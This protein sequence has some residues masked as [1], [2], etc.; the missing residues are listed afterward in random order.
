MAPWPDQQRRTARIRYAWDDHATASCENSRR[1]GRAS[2]TK[3]CPN[4]ASQAEIGVFA[5]LGPNRMGRTKPTR[6]RNQPE[7]QAEPRESA[8]TRPMRLV[9]SERNRG[10]QAGPARP[11]TPSLRQ[12]GRTS[13]ARPNMSAA[14]RTNKP[15]EAKTNNCARAE[16]T[17]EQG[18][19]A[20]PM[21]TRPR[22]TKWVHSAKTESTR[23][24]QEQL[25]H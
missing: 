14:P 16:S 7:N 20:A 1:P 5:A 17:V 18:E 12:R 6:S 19:P 25:L 4:R 23:R 11:K 21:P 15:D 13:R 2:S 3:P 24:R 8:A 9:R 22:L 10:T